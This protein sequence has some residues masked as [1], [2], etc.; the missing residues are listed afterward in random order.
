M[1]KTCRKIKLKIGQEQCVVVQDTGT[2]SF[3]MIRMLSEQSVLCRSEAKG[4]V[5]PGIHIGWA[6]T[7]RVK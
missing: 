3:F 5:T 4:A 6:S 1:N 2:R 7:E